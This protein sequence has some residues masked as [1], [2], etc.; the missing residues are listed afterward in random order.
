MTD[1]TDTAGVTFS[2]VVPVYNEQDGLEN[3]YRRLTAA[4]D[5]LGE[6]YEIVFVNDGSQDE[7]DTVLTHLADEDIRVRVVEFSRNFGHQIAVTA[8]YD[9]AA[10]R[11]VVSLDSDCQHPP[12]LIGEMVR[13]WREG[14]EIVYTVRADTEGISPVRRAIGR[15]AY[16]II[17]GA[18]GY[19]LT[20]Q[21]D[22]RLMDRRA[23]DVLRTMRE[24]ARF[25]RGLVRWIGFRQVAMPYTAEKRAIGQSSYTLKQLVDM[26]TAGV[27]N[28]STA[29]LKLVTRVGGAFIAAA[30]LYAIVSLVLWP[31]GLAA[32][33]LWH[34]AAGIVGL[35]GVQFVL[36]GLVG[37]YVGRIFDEAKDRPIYVVRGTLGFPAAEPAP[38]DGRGAEAERPPAAADSKDKYSVFT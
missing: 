18:S 20:D 3:F 28:F 23:V 27:F 35:F 9:H 37:E 26:T 24:K 10:G 8:G 6:P 29:P 32:S 16:R 17:R 30:V 25:V 12:E 19:D 5:A 36:L 14:F 2:F 34:L 11:A 33:G 38:P 31:M 21:A 13:L 7:T 4:A 15:L 1:S 22:F